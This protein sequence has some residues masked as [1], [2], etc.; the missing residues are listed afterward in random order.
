MVGIGNTNVY[1]R[2]HVERQYL[3]GPS[4]FRKLVSLPT[5]ECKDNSSNAGTYFYPII[6]EKPKD[7][8]FSYPLK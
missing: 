6:E 2:K 5:K 7:A 1:K 8:A 3:K 4:S